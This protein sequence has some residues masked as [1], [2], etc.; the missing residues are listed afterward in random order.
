MN[1]GLTGFR[2]SG[3]TTVFS[4]FLGIEP[5][6]SAGKTSAGVLKIPDNR[7]DK[8]GELFNPKKVTHACVNLE[9]CPSLDSQ[10]KQERIKL[11]D[12]LKRKDAVIL[13][14][15]GF[16][17]TNEEGVLNK[18]KQLRF[19]MIMSDLDIVTKRIERLDQ[20]MKK[21]A[22]ERMTKKK[23][24]AVMKKLQPILEGEGMLRG[25]ELDDSDLRVIHNAGL[26]SLKPM[27]YLINISEDMG[28][29][30]IKELLKQTKDML[31][32][33]K[34][35]SP[36]F[37]VNAPLEL[38]LSL[39]DPEEAG[40][41]MNEYGIETSG[42]D[43]AIQTAYS[44]LNLITFYTVG[45]D[46]CRSWNIPQGGTALDAAAAIHTD[47]AKG[48]IRA[49]VIDYNDMLETGTLNNARKAGKLRLEGK[50]YHVKDGEIVHIMFNI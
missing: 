29:D 16:K 44:L 33:L 28:E 15:G 41:F 31:A 27:M 39:M 14:A 9:E 12:A 1:I 49:E 48:F 43:K 37:A 11:W 36:V 13:V 47:L 32:A 24:M 25:Q 45:E 6:E 42:R 50:T 10:V 19:E 22:K 8:L 21:N 3:K 23:E 2:S 20:D 38:E 46:E 35:D 18:I 17:E 7:L 4:S 34:D 26:I 40:E 30:R 5:S